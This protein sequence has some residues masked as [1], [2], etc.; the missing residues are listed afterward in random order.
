MA[1]LFKRIPHIT[2]NLKDG[3]PIDL[4][5]DNA[6]RALQD[7]MIWQ[8]GGISQALRYVD[9]SGETKFVNF[10]CL[11]GIEIKPQTKE[12]V[13]GRPCEDITCFE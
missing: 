12:A 2:L 6:Q 7:Y 5:G 3:S 9:A 8:Q 13:T 11:C 4:D 1:N 10:D